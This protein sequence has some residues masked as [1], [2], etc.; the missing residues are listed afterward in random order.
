[1][2]LNPKVSREVSPAGSAAAVTVSDST[3]YD[4]PGR[5]LYVG[6]G[7]N[8]AVRMAGG[9]QTLVFVN[10]QGGSVLPICVDQVRST[11]TTASDIVIIY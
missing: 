11:S 1:M 4:P 3:V 5:A 8:V 6:T 2:S 10:V 7:G 9:G